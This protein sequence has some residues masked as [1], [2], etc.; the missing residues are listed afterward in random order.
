MGA[1][2]VKVKKLKSEEL[3][4]IVTTVRKSLAIEA[5]VL[6][7]H[8]RECGGIKVCLLSFEKYY[9]RNGS[10]ANLSMM[11]MEANGVQTVDCIGSGG[12]NG[13]LNLSWGANRN[14][15]RLGYEELL[16]LGFVDDQEELD[17][18]NRNASSL[19]E[20]LERLIEEVAA[21]QEKLKEKN[22]DGLKEEQRKIID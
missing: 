1:T 6:G 8:W 17:K 9:F 4:D 2:T 10:Y 12:G 18:L 11:F 19:D 20:G 15:A 21:K 7:E 16:K 3:K 22:Y 5:E 13:L 14:F